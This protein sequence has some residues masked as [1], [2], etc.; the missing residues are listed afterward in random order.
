MVINSLFYTSLVAHTCE[1][2]VSLLPGLKRSLGWTGC[3][4]DVE[5]LLV[6]LRALQKSIDLKSR[7]GAVDSFRIV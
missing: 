3:G 7:S 4:S 1:P 5:A 2:I 6:R